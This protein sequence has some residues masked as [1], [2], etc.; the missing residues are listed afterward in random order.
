MTSDGNTPGR[1]FIAR[2]RWVAAIAAIAAVIA[3]SLAFWLVGGPGRALAARGSQTSTVRNG[4]IWLHGSIT[5][6]TCDM[7]KTHIAI[8][9]VGCSITVNGYDVSVVP[10]NARLAGTPGRVTGLDA[11]TDQTGRQADVYAR[12][13]GPHSA[14]I[15]IAPKYYTRISG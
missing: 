14:T 4:E 6:D 5:Q 9:D 3:G 8:G 13:T 10:G 2:R 15:L 1:R 11:A 7:S 12:L